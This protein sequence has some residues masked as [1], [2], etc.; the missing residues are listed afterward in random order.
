[1]Q[2]TFLIIAGILGALAVGLGA[3]GAHA[4]RNLLENNNRLETYETAVK[5]HF[6]HVLALIAIALLFEKANATYLQYSGWA[7]ITGIVIFSGSLYAL[8]LTN[9]SKLGAI[10]P[11]GGLAL[12]LGWIFLVLAVVKN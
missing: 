1:M 4:L 10:T 6:W 7:F 3:F 9:I 5:Y 12:I 11:I 2:K 8:C